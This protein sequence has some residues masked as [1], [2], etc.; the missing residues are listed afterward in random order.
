MVL[1]RRPPRR[2]CKIR[3]EADP[4]RGRSPA[5][6]ALCRASRGDQAR[7][8]LALRK[9]MPLLRSAT[10][11]W[12]PISRTSG[13]FGPTVKALQHYRRRFITLRTG[14][15]NDNLI[16]YRANT[17]DCGP[18]PLKPRC[19]PNAPARKIL[20]SIHEG[21][22]YIAHGIAKTEAHHTSRPQRKKP[23]RATLRPR[24][25]STMPCT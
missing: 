23:R 21:A 17:R 2:A 10:V 22:R 6:Q 11:E 15:P 4:P 5:G 20:R 24:C 7:H 12:R 9:R 14:V 1:P 16:R 3:P 8:C 25:L 18:C 13:W 19:C